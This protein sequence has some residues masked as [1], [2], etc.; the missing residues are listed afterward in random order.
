MDMSTRQKLAELIQ[1]DI[2]QLREKAEGRCN[3]LSWP[4]PVLAGWHANT[5]DGATARRHRLPPPPP[6]QPPA[7]QFPTYQSFACGC[8]T[9]HFLHS[10][11]RAAY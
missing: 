8:C 6:V 11:N 4:S 2:D 9:H 10:A 1:K 5:G 7:G 3:G